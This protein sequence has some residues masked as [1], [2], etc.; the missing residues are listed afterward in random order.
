MRR[1][2]L[3]LLSVAAFAPMAMTSEAMAEDCTKDVLAAFDRQHKAKAFRT[4]LT[5]PTAEGP[6][7]VTWDYLPPDRA[8]QTVKS[9][10]MAGV[11]HT[12]LVGDRAFAGSDEAYEELLPQF[13]QSI[14]AEVASAVGPPPSNIG[15]FECGGKK[16]FD[17]KELLAYSASDKEIKPGT[18][19]D[20]ILA[21]TIYVD[22][23]SGLPAYNVI[24][25]V[26]GKGEPALK[27]TYSYPTDVVIE[28]PVGAP[29]QKSR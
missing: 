7:E 26:S 25:A 27:V 10:A 24:A 20:D 17:G 15:V 28:A 3:V 1:F 2:G 11:Q 8:L 18:S 16:T 13:K 19:P 12:M 5:Q 29:I 4:S 14:Q 9:P 22:P 6:A 21:R 23:A